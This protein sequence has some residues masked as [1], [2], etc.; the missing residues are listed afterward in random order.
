MNARNRRRQTPL[1]VAVNKGHVAVIKMLLKQNCHPS[2]QVS[3]LT[4]SHIHH[5][6]PYPSLP[7]I[8]IHPSL[9]PSC[10]H[11][12][13]LPHPHPSLTPSHIHHL[14]LPHPH[15]SLTPSHI[16]HLHPPSSIPLPSS[17]DTEGDTPLHDAISKKRDDMVSLLLE[18]NAEIA[19]TN[20]NGFNALHHAALR[21]NTGAVRLLLPYLIPGCS[22]NEAKDDGFTA[23]HLSSLNNHLEVSQALIQNV[24]QLAQLSGRRIIILFSGLH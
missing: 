11:H 16:H 6:Y 7:Y 20:N 21:G 4:H 19:I 14:H 10:I 15:P 5:L 9:T 18:G 3:C 2:L 23:L 1:H 8:L 13:H 24:R 12:S 17:Q 22:V